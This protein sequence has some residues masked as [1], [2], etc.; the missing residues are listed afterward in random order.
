MYEECILV[1][2]ANT[3]LTYLLYHS[4]LSRESHVYTIRLVYDSI[5]KGVTHN[6]HARTLHVFVYITGS[7][8]CM[9]HHAQVSGSNASVT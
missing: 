1:Y 2:I 3:F 4:S 6:T 5:R 9:L 8:T 7:V